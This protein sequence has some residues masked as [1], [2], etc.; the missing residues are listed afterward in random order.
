MRGR[1]ELAAIAAMAD[2]VRGDP[3]GLS[4]LRT[5]EIESAGSAF[6]FGGIGE[7]VDGSPAAQPADAGDGRIAVLH[8]FPGPLPTR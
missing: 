6:R 8:T 3:R 5:T 4:V 1:A 7:F 2:R